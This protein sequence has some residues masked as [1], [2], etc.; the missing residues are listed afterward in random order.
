M[1]GT[2]LRKRSKNKMPSMPCSLGSKHSSIA[3][4]KLAA[5]AKG[6]KRRQVGD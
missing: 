3:Q 5:Q 4:T 6:F 1:L 2:N